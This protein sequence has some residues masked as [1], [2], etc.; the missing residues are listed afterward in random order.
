MNSNLVFRNIEQAK[1][2]RSF[3]PIYNFGTNV[4]I[5]KYGSMAMEH[6]KKTAPIAYEAYSAYN[7]FQY[8][9]A[10][11]N[12]RAAMRMAEA[13]AELRKQYPAPKTDD[14][15]TLAEHNAQLEKMAE[16]IA[17]NEVV[18]QPHIKDSEIRA[19][20]HGRMN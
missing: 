5:G 2:Y 15:F 10:E 17:I 11:I 1:H 4:I 19:A 18:L 9:L 8:I 12:Q 16:E 3:T 7:E 14:F 13:K 6:M 20:R